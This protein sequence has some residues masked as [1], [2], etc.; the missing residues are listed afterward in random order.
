M[1]RNAVLFNEVNAFVTVDDLLSCMG[2]ELGKGIH[3]S[4][5]AIKGHD[6]LVFKEVQYSTPNEPVVKQIED[7]DKLMQAVKHDNIV[8]WRKVIKDDK[9][10]C[11]VMDRYD[12]SLDVFLRERRHKGVPMDEDMVLDFSRQICSAL[13][14]IHNLNKELPNGLPILSVVHGDIKPANILVADQ[15]KKF[16]I[17]DFAFGDR[18]MASSMAYYEAPEVRSGGAPT[19]ASD[20][21]SI[22]VILY[23]LAVGNIT[24]IRTIDFTKC[25]R[26]FQLNLNAVTY[27]S[28]RA[29]ISRLLVLN[30]SSRITA[31]ELC[32]V[33]ASKDVATTLSIRHLGDSTGMHDK[34]LKTLME[35]VASLENI[36]AKQASQ[37]ESLQKKNEELRNAG[38]NS[39]DTVANLAF[40]NLMTA[41]QSNNIETVRMILSSGVSMGKQDSKGMTALMYAAEA[42][43][44][45]IVE[46]LLEHEKCI[47]DKNGW[48]ALMRAAQKNSVNSVRLL[49]K[50]EAGMQSNNGR[51]A[52]ME[53]VAKKSLN[54]AVEL[55]ECEHGYQDRSGCTAL[56]YAAE[57]GLTEI[58]TRLLDYE[59]RKQDDGG[60]T[61]LMKAA[62]KNR[63]DVVNVL[64]ACEAGLKNKKGETALEI[65]RD[66]GYSEV[67][68]ILMDFLGE[69]V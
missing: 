29:I 69:T 51:T 20:M 48:T 24:I 55:I 50:V 57:K 63:V 46:L 26:D 22:G 45:Q 19:F 52:L 62:A 35:R 36:V 59:K 3:G 14:Y 40:V 58:V 41:V 43:R 5:F 44:F 25:N 8:T 56:M 64:A 68:E 4:V 30:P 38:P 27:P 13:A 6:N 11:I 18:N 33:L 7:S 31:K 23:E 9:C 65:A 21:W 2:T 37:I 67:E 54:S 49:I 39:S 47:R 15:G 66:R 32:D 42:D 17:A 53:A 16:S 10:I 61:A 12:C 34:M 60:V 28:I 1:T